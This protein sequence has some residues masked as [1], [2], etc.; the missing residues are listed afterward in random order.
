MRYGLNNTTKVILLTAVV[1]DIGFENVTDMIF[2]KIN[3]CGV[4][5]ILASREMLFSSCCCLTQMSYRTCT[6]KRKHS[7][8]I[9][10]YKHAIVLQFLKSVTLQIGVIYH[11]MDDTVKCL[12]NIHIK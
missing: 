3:G 10:L 7:F 1:R 4:L 12:F 8:N 9:Q 2:L 11:R 6:V 5:L